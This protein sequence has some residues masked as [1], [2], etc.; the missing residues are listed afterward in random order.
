MGGEGEQEGEVGGE[1]ENGLEVDEDEI[2]ISVGS[3]CRAIY[4]FWLWF[5]YF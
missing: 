1:E 4:I 5:K 3:I 2:N